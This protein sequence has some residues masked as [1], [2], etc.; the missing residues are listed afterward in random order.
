[1]HCEMASGVDFRRQEIAATKTALCSTTGRKIGGKPTPEFVTNGGLA[2]DRLTSGR[3]VGRTVDRSAGRPGGWLGG[4]PANRSKVLVGDVQ[5]PQD[6]L[7]LA[8]PAH[9]LEEVRGELYPHEV[10]QVLDPREALRL[11]G[12]SDQ[13][14]RLPNAACRV[15][16]NRA[17]R[18]Q[19][20]SSATTLDH[21][22]RRLCSPSL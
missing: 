5:V 21:P 3:S 9:H 19:L 2:S 6:V 22:L 17:S 11:S 20:A 4:R 7:K 1:M 10:V 8:H 15:F 13:A 14:G 12:G 16:K 18:G